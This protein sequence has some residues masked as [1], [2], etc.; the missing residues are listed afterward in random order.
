MKEYNV[1]Y[2][3]EFKKLNP[4][5][6]GLRIEDNRIVA[7]TCSEELTEEEIAQLEKNIKGKIVKVE[8]PEGKLISQKTI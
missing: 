8:I 7:I 4:K 6:V 3:H 2:E 1:I 5:I